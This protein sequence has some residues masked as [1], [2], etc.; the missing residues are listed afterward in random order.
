VTMNSAQSVTANFV[1]VA[2][3]VTA[4][5]GSISFGNV[6]LCRNK[7]QMVTLRDSATSLV[8]IGPVSIIDVTGNASDFTFRTYSTTGILGP[9]KGR[10][11]Q[12]QVEF[13]PSQEIAESA[14]LNIATN[15]PGS[16]VQ[17]QITGTGVKGPKGCDL[18]P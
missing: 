3:Q 5:P 4:S 13:A 14:T 17:V 10:S 7:K 8:Q 6:D 2:V 18:N 15:A 9:G 1:A 12:I 11:Y 16:P